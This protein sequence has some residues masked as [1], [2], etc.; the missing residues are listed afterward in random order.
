MIGPVDAGHFEVLMQR[1]REAAGDMVGLTENSLPHRHLQSYFLAFGPRALA[2]PVLQQ[3]L[4]DMR[5]LPSKELVIDLY[6]T[7]LTRQ[8]E[9]A[10]LRAVTLFPPLYR[11]P[12]SAD[13][14]LIRWQ[15]LL[16]AGFPYVKASLLASP[17]HAAA[18]RAHVPAGLLPAAAERKL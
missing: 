14:T 2:S 16:N 9:S 3:A 12:Y 10:G 17:R 18:V 1:L 13:D 15:E 6:E 5:S 4:G 11:D 7:T 8:L